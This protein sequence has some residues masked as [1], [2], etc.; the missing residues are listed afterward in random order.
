MNFHRG[1]FLIDFW[2]SGQRICKDSSISRGERTYRRPR[3]HLMKEHLPSRTR[4]LV[5]ERQHYPRNLSIDFY[6]KFC[7][8]RGLFRSIPAIIAISSELRDILIFIYSLT[9]LCADR[10]E[11][12]RQ[13]NEISQLEMPNFFSI[14]LRYIIY[15]IY[16]I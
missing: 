13:F 3:V 11:L 4:R 1:L 12:P 8:A 16:L 7:F 15:F 2:Y 5:S 14:F 10:L 9:R 6:F